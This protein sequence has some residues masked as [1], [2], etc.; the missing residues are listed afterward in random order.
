MVAIPTGLEVTKSSIF[1]LAMVFVS[2]LVIH[3]AIAVMLKKKKEELDNLNTESKDYEDAVKA[4]KMVGL[5]YKWFP[6]IAIVLI[7]I[8]FYL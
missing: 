5:L 7:L 6:A 8:G 4:V 3:I 1:T 2:Y